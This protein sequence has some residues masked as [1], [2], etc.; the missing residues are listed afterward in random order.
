MTEDEDMLDGLRERAK[1][2]RD[3]SPK[4]G[5]ITPLEVTAEH[6]EWAVSEIVSLRAKLKKI[7]THP[8]TPELIRQYAAGML[9]G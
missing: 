5:S 4:S 9:G 2:I 7:A 6:I 8:D 1:I 3:A